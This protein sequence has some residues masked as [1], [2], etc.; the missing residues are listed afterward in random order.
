MSSRSFVTTLACKRSRKSHSGEITNRKSITPTSAIP[1]RITN[2]R[3]LEDRRAESPAAASRTILLIFAESDIF[4]RSA[5]RGRGGSNQFFILPLSEHQDSVVAFR[6][7]VLGP[8]L[9][10]FPP[11]SHFFAETTAVRTQP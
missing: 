9:L 11:A 4:L 5:I 8:F 6:L 2:R 10:A 7:A 3:S 1:A